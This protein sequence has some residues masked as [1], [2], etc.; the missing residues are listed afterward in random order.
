M[1]AVVAVVRVVRKVGERRPHLLSFLAEIFSAV[2]RG[3]GSLLFVPPDTHRARSTNISLRPLEIPGGT[4]QRLALRGPAGVSRKQR[5]L[6]PP[7]ARLVWK[8]GRGQ[9]RYMRP[10]PASP[11]RHDP[12][13]V[14]HHAVPCRAF[15]ILGANWGP[16]CPLPFPFVS[17]ALI[18]A[19]DDRG[20]LKTPQHSGRNNFLGVLG[21]NLAK[22]HHR[23]GRLA[24]NSLGVTRATV[25]TS[26]WTLR[27]SACCIQSSARHDF[28]PSLVAS[29]RSRLGPR[30]SSPGCL[31]RLNAAVLTR[32]RGLQQSMDDILAVVRE[33]GSDSLAPLLLRP[34]R[35]TGKRVGLRTPDAVARNPRTAGRVLVHSA[36]DSQEREH[37]YLPPLSQNTKRNRPATGCCVARTA[38]SE[39]SRVPAC[40]VCVDPVH[41][42]HREFLCR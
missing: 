4:G 27:R 19:P 24:L 36:W 20:L 6:G 23:G 42:L 13:V 33:I 38:F 31:Q 37:E 22:G 12:V 7:H 28:G 29:P 15:G 21:S 17:P 11:K 40:L 16:S 39:G 5:R 2:E 32:L 35:R 14:L 9:R 30:S 8:G 34:S 1:E 26:R 18:A 41:V 3:S 10:S 25:S